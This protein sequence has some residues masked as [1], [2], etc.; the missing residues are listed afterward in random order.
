MLLLSGNTIPITQTENCWI[1]NQFNDIRS[2]TYL[3]SKKRKS[4][5]RSRKMVMVKKRKQR[6]RN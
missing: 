6:S 5:K 1:P 4:K 2:G 3:F